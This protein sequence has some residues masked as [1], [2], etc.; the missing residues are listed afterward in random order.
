M[1]RQFK[2]SA[3]YPSLCHV[4]YEI[5][6][7][8][9]NIT[10]Y[11][12]TLSAITIE[13]D[14]DES[15]GSD[16]LV[17]FH[18]GDHY[19]SVRYKNGRRPEKTLSRSSSERRTSRQKSR[20]SSLHRGASVNGIGTTSSRSEFTRSSQSDTV[21]TSASTIS[22]TEES[23]CDQSRSEQK[24]IPL[25]TVVGVENKPTKRSSP[26]PCGSGRRY[27]KCCWAKERSESRNRKQ[28][29]KTGRGSGGD[30]RMQHREES[31]IVM[32]GKFRVLQI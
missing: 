5:F 22:T 30:A 23:L 29:E 3:L 6:S 31:A 10:V 25:A 9:R 21:T 13:H 14:K 24:K 32:K 27:K 11:S 18:S 1:Y 20:R 28:K 4:S 19:N 2:S 16:L 12:A 17:S 26:C 7:D 15:T 8:R